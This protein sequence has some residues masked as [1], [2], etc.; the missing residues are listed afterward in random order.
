MVKQRRIRGRDTILGRQILV[1]SVGTYLSFRAEKPRGLPPRYEGGPW[2]WVRG[3]VE[4]P[5]RDV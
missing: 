3:T 1:Q 4:E 2:L 5:I